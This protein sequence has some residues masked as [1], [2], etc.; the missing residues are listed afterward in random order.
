M[1]FSDVA[2]VALAGLSWMLDAA[3]ALPTK[4]HQDVG[5][6]VESVP[7]ATATADFLDSTTAAVLTEYAEPGYGCYTVKIVFTQENPTTH[8]TEYIQEQ[9]TN[10]C[11]SGTVQLIDTVTEYSFVEE[12]YIFQTKIFKDDEYEEGFTLGPEFDAYG[13]L[14]IRGL[15]GWRHTRNNWVWQYRP[16][17]TTVYG[18]GAWRTETESR[19][20]TSLDDVAKWF[21]DNSPSPP[22]K[23]VVPITASGPG[24]MKVYHDGELQPTVET[25]VPFD[26]GMDILITSNPLKTSEQGYVVLADPDISGEFTGWLDST[27][28]DKSITVSMNPSD[29]WMTTTSIHANFQDAQQWRTF[30]VDPKGTQFF[31]KP[32]GASDPATFRGYTDSFGF[33]R[34]EPVTIDSTAPVYQLDVGTMTFTPTGELVGDLNLSIKPSLSLEDPFAVYDSSDPVQIVT[35]SVSTGNGP[36]DVVYI[37]SHVSL[38]WNDDEILPAESEFIEYRL[39]DGAADAIVDYADQ[40]NG[41]QTFPDAGEWMNERFM[42]VWNG[43]D[44]VS[45]RDNTIDPLQTREDPHYHWLFSLGKVMGTKHDDIFVGDAKDNAF[46]TNGGNDQATG[47]AGADSFHLSGGSIVIMDFAPSESDDIDI[48]RKSYTMTQMD[49]DYHTHDLVYYHED[50]DLYIE[51]KST[52]QTLLRLPGVTMSQSVW[53][54]MW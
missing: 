1:K 6:N 2:I 40:T 34:F 36:I 50:G 8:E 33:T 29:P 43:E 10:V 37:P 48:D 13:N 9:T 27:K 47:N 32:F 7:A 44:P 23:A 31:S 12:W 25:S 42:L 16:F 17:Q 35:A 20:Y 4:D 28:D 45:E 46:W 21:R 15:A 22:N 14:V 39:H 24:S 26:I 38:A 53:D 52:G 41:I 3:Q 51:I 18:F 11:T 19:S 54:Q 30:K 5:V 49:P